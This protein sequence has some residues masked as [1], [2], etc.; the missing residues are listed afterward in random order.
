MVAGKGRARLL[1]RNHPLKITLHFL[2]TGGGEERY[3]RVYLPTREFMLRLLPYG[4]AL[5]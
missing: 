5:R 3:Q 2:K 4:S 1:E